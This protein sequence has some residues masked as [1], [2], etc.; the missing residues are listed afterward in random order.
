MHQA[1]GFLLAKDSCEKRIERP[2]MGAGFY[3]K[4][5]T[6]EHWTGSPNKSMDQIGKTCPKNV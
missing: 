5:V 2:N 4:V 6:G 3:A 1:V